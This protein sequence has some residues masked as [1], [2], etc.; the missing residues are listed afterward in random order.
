VDDNA[1]EC[2]LKAGKIARRVQDFARREAKPGMR[3]LDYCEKIE[4]MILS[5]G[6]GIAFPVNLSVNEC[7]AHYTPPEGDQ[8]VLAESDVLKVDLGTHVEGYIADCAFTYCASG[9][10]GALVSASKTALAAALG[11]MRAGASIRDV[12]GAIEATIRGAGFLPV[13][14][15]CGHSLEKSRIHAGLEIP[16]TAR[17]S[18]VLREGDVFAVEPFASTGK[19]FVREGSLCEIFALAQL[20]KKARLPASRSLLEFLEKECGTLPFA[21]RWLSKSG[22]DDAKISFAIADLSRQGVLHGYPVLNDAKGSLVSQ[23]ETSVIV[24]KS[25]VRDILA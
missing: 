9:K 7:A 11:K 20:G 22:L 12:G 2:F 4:A 23:D 13:E 21:K 16:N 25:G 10:N 8:T 15:L 19:G 14:N 24:E 17:G 3:L 6:A 1:I 5:E 18:Y